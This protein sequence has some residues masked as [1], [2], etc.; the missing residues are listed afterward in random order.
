MSSPTTKRS[1][2]PSPRRR[3]ARDDRHHQLLEVSWRLI[4]T[5]GTDALTLGRLAEQAGVTKPLVY[6]HFGTRDGL[7][8]AL[9]QDYDV[10]QTAVMD[11][12]LAASKSTLKDKARVIA[13]SYVDCVLLQGREMPGVL[14]ALAGS[15]DLEKIKRDYHIA[16]IEKCRTILAPFAGANGIASAALWAM[17]GAAEALSYAAALKEVTPT[18][19][20]DELFATIV[21]MAMRS[22]SPRTSE[23]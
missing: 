12:A 15:P 19:A 8:V 10:R 6:D 11:S 18:Q 4:R 17:L 21:A 22:R 3:L 1:A 9:Y 20:K 13:S 5:E 7:L 16:F 14:A 2:P 23:C